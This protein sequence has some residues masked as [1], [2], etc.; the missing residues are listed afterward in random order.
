MIVEAQWPQ[1]MSFTVNSI[2]AQVPCRTL[3]HGERHA[4]LLGVEQ[5]LSPS[6]RPFNIA[7]SL[8]AKAIVLGGIVD[9]VDCPVLSATLFARGATLRTSPSVKAAKQE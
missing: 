4:D 9:E 7:G 8:T 2:M 6:S 3:H 5:H 1:V